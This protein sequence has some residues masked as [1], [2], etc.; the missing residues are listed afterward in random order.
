MHVK[1]KE[2][3]TSLY[4]KWLSNAGFIDCMLVKIRMMKDCIVIPPR[5]PASCGV[6]PKV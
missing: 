6:V 2:R 3:K 4:G 5:A 1:L